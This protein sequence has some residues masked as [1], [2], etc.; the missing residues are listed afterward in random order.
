MS[1]RFFV[2]SKMASRERERLCQRSSVDL[3]HLFTMVSPL[4]EQV[5][6]QGDHAV[7]E[8]TRKFDG[9]DLAPAKFRVPT[10]VMDV[11]LETLPQHLREAL[12]ISISNIKLFHE[13]QKE[14]GGWET[15]LAPGILAGERVVPIPS[16]GLYIPRG[17]GSFPSM[18]MM[19]GIPAKVAGVGRIVVVTPPDI[20]GSADAATLAAARLIG[21][22]EIYAVGGVQAIAA[23]AFGTETIPKVAKIVGPGSGYVMAAK[24]VVSPYVDTGLPA[25]PSESIVLADHTVEP[26]M[27][28]TDLLIEAEHG[29]D[30]SAFLVTTSSVMAES[31]L[32]LIPSLV[33]KLPEPRRTF[34]KDVLE[35]NGGVLLAS[36]MTEAIDFINEFAPEHLQ[37]LTADP[38]SVLEKVKYAGEALLGHFT[39]G[40]LANYSLG[41]N[42]IL[43]TSGFARTWSSLS[44]RDFTRRMSFA[45]VDQYAFR[46]LA[47]KTAVI[48]EYEG[49]FAHA[50]AL[51]Y[52]LRKQ[53]GTT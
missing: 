20:N 36:D 52:R 43:P 47:P 21:I 16:V 11:A 35:R 40:T 31:A 34:C 46:K 23:L 22:D 49:F 15:Q 2:L 48:A 33:S 41:P 26:E 9:A 8:L 17:K 14:Q 37:V 5:R 1:T 42:A 4:V 13:K 29:S 30:S 24:Q 28:V 18:M 10:G 32:A 6:S 38:L 7:S 39:P 3:K 27:A 12:E 45:M 50:E 53:G 25:G 44:V 19:A 51:N